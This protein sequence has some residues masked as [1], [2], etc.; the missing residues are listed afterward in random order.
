MFERSLLVL[1]MDSSEV[2]INGSENKSENLYPTLSADAEDGLSE[3]SSLCVNCHEQVITLPKHL[4]LFVLTSA[5]NKQY[6]L[7]M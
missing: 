1:R 3:L 5:E 4:S 2:K 6:F 7:Q